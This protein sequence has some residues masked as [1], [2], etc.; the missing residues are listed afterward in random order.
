MTYAPLLTLAQLRSFAFARAT[1]E[2]DILCV[3]QRLFSSRVGFGACTY[4][5]DGWAE[6]SVVSACVLWR[7]M[8]MK[9]QE[10]QVMLQNHGA[11]IFQDAAWRARS[12]NSSSAN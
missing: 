10:P 4:S 9:F 12:V 1:G 3:L 7:M 5:W 6:Q 8:R 11:A 2:I